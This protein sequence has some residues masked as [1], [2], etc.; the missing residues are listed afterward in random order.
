MNPTELTAINH[1]FPIDQM[2]KLRYS[3]LRKTAARDKLT[4]YTEGA[5]TTRHDPDYNKLVETTYYKA[6][7]DWDNIDNQI[8][9]TDATH[10]AEVQYDKCY[11]MAL[12]RVVAESTL[13]MEQFRTV[14]CVGGDG[15]I[16]LRTKPS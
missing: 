6:I 9:L 14:S 3:R 11:S 7:F 4:M 8:A 12:K 13:T 1:V 2:I 16:C 5:T 15:A 10:A